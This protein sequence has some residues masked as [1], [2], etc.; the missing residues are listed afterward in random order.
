MK[1]IYTLLMVLVVALFSCQPIEE[2]GNGNTNNE[3]NQPPAEGQPVDTALQS[4]TFKPQQAEGPVVI[5]GQGGASQVELDF[6]IEPKSSVTHISK[7]WRST[8]SCV[9]KYTSPQS[10]Q[11][12]QIPIIG[13]KANTKSGILSLTLSGENLSDGFFRGELN[14]QAVLKITLEGKSVSSETI[15]LVADGNYEDLKGLQKFAK[16]YEVKVLSFNVRLDTSE[17]DPNNNWPKRKAACVELI[18]NQ[19]PTLVGFQEAKYTSQW[20]YLKEQLKDEYDGWGV[21]RDTGKESGSGEVMGILY[22]KS[23]LQKVDGGTFWLSETPDVCS[24]GW[25]AD[26]K[27]TATW[28]IFKHILSNRYFL[29]VNTHLD[30]KGTVARVKGLE[31]LAAFIQKY[32]QYKAILS[33]DMNVEST[34]EAFNVLTSSLMHNTRDVAPAGHTDS[35]TTYNAWSTSKMSIIDH[36]YCSKSL[37]VVEYHTVN[38]NYG[39]PYI[40][41]HYPVYAIIKLM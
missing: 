23:K 14:A 19:K 38:E 2:S 26:C 15:T 40:S 29:Y 11:S 24:K 1:K 5:S 33:G 25:D 28:G 13:C 34:H 3:N 41:D 35:N 4:V 16:R 32:S 30:H 8:L 12:V 21:D 20:L 36:I 6:E 17:S 27:R 9:A 37:Q 18:K 39:V 10:S 22:D 7:N 31:Q